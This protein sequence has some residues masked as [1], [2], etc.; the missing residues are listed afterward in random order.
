MIILYLSIS[1]CKVFL[2]ILNDYFKLANWV[3]KSYNY[4]ALFCYNYLYFSSSPWYFSVSIAFSFSS[5]ITVF[6]KFP[7]VYLELFFNFS[8]LASNVILIDSSFSLRAL[9]WRLDSYLIAFILSSKL[10][11][12]DSSCLSESLA[13]LAL[14][15]LSWVFKAI[16]FSYYIFFYKY[17]L[18]S[19]WYLFFKSSEVFS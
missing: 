3:F 7:S 2:S 4:R 19:Y 14:Y 13:R 5:S 16:V 1:D 10:E 8:Y 12:F 9:I 15:S 6:C 18:E 11:L 17:S